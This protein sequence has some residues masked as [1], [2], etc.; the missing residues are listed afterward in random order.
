MECRSRRP[1]PSA[2]AI[3]AC[4]AVWL[5]ACS[6]RG[7]TPTALP[8]PVVSVQRTALPPT[9]TPVAVVELSPEPSATSTATHTRAPTE[10]PEPSRTP[11]PTPEPVLVVG[12][13]ANV[14]GGPGVNYPIVGGLQAGERAAVIGRSASGT[15]FVIAFAAAANG[16]GWVSETVGEFEGDAEG[17]PVVAAPPTPR[18]TSTFTPTPTPLPTNTP[19]SLRGIS[20]QLTLCDPK[21]TYAAAV[22]RI[23]FRETI[24]NSSARTVT[25][26]L[27][28]VLATSLSGGPS[29]FQTSWSGDLAIDPG[30]TGPTDRCGGSWED[31][32]HIDVPGT[33]RL[34][35]QICYSTLDV[36]RTPGGEW[37]TLT[38]G[39]T[40]TVN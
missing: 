39:I 19:A 16:Q 38:P 2:P 33:Y 23:C 36:C 15:W 27:L 13:S 25:Y 9:S 40:I 10:T 14:R 24:R 31:G 29:Q 28:G 1:S 35:L 32:I 7:G 21:T 17:V 22:E 11:T 37:E 20:G 8:T 5:A 18:P 6:P 3:L 30:C 26:G 12:Q 34:T 4:A